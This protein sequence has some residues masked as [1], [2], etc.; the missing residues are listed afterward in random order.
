MGGKSGIVKT[1]SSEPTLY[2]GFSANLVR[3]QGEGT[4]L[5]PGFTSV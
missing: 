4:A 3:Y 5:I 2:A 1:R